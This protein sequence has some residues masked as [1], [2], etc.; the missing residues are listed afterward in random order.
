MKRRAL[1]G[2]C[3]LL[4]SCGGNTDAPVAAAE[5]D[6]NQDAEEPGTTDSDEPGDDTPAPALTD[7]NPNSGEQV[8]V[9]GLIGTEPDPMPDPTPETAT[10]AVPSSGC[11]QAPG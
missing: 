6:A 10:P 1:Y 3:L 4:T 2:F 11:A 9:G 8:E 5:E 7:P